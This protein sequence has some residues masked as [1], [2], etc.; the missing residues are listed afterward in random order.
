MIVAPVQTADP[1]RQGGETVEALFGVNLV[2]RE[3]WLEG[4]RL[5]AEIGLPLYRDL[6][7]PQLETDF[8]FTLG[9]QKVL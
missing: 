1:D 9:W 6:N 3:G 2:G 7:G 4:H 5:A 8:T